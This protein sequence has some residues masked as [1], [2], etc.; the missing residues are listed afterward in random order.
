MTVED[1]PK[2][3]DEAE[4]AE[5][6]RHIRWLD[7]LEDKTVFVFGV[8]GSALMALLTPVAASFSIYML[9]TVRILEGLFEGINFPSMHALLSRWAP[10]YERSRM[11]SFCIAGINPLDLAPNHASVIFGISNT[12]A[13]IPGIISPLLAG[14]IV[15]DKAR[16]QWQI[17]FF[18]VVAINVI[19]CLVYWFFA[20]GELQQWAQTS[21]DCIATSQDR[22]KIEEKSADNEK[23]YS[24]ENEGD[25]SEDVVLWKRKRYLV[26]IL[27]CVGFGPCYPALLALVTRWVPIQERTS[28]ISLALFGLMLGSVITLPITGAITVTFGWQSASHILGACGLIW[29]VLY[30]I[31]VKAG[32]EVDSHCS[33]KEKKFILQ[34]LKGVSV[35]KKYK[36]PWKGI[37]TSP[38]V[39]S[40]GIVCFAQMLGSSIFLSQ[41]PRFF[42]DIMKLN[43]DDASYLSAIP[44][45]FLCVTMLFSGIVVDMVIRKKILEVRQTRRYFTL[46]A[47]FLEG[48]FVVAASQSTDKISFIT[49][50]TI[51]VMWEPLA[52]SCATV[53]VVDLCPVSAPI[54]L[55]MTATL[56]GSAGII[57]P[58]LVLG[59]G[60]GIAAIFTFLTPSIAHL[61]YPWLMTTRAIEGLLQGA[62]QPASLWILTRWAPKYERSRM[63]GMTLFGI[64]VGSVAALPMTGALIVN[65][66]W[67][68][69]SY[70]F[71]SSSLLLAIL[72][73]IVM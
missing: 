24:M 35:G 54:I 20:K 26:F 11:A 72:Y 57:A 33:E 38:A 17:V 1:I 63:I 42:T 2:Q 8:G 19:G 51:G 4:R 25:V 60:A 7:V 31:M 69:V 9:M 12:I 50:L 21:S 49:Y 34:N 39:W 23:S 32:P 45:I 40:I 68:T 16:E 61:G 6:Y 27:T 44:F 5:S 64:Y 67:R 55:S 70:V 53:N 47:F 3:G 43:I 56:S 48:S 65:F 29:A 62:S 59:F 37:L 52:I 18:I 41:L 22:H 71:G 46:F 13:N 66:G 28:M 10:V 58:I 30:G 14:A 36:I 73:L 15:T